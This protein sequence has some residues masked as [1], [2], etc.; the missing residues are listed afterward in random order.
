MEEL[1]EFFRHLH[2]CLESL[3]KDDH[4]IHEIDPIDRFIQTHNLL[5]GKTKKCIEL[6][7]DPTSKT[8]EISDVFMC[9]IPAKEIIKC[10]INAAKKVGWLKIILTD[11]SHLNIGFEGVP[12]IVH[13]DLRKLSLLKYGKTWYSHHFGFERVINSSSFLDEVERIVKTTKL[14]DLI[15]APDLPDGIEFQIV[16]ELIE[17]EVNL[18]NNVLSIS[19]FFQTMFDKIPCKKQSSTWSDYTCV[20]TVKFLSKAESFSKLVD[21]VWDAVSHLAGG[22][23]ILDLPYELNLQKGGRK[24][25]SVKKKLQ[26]QKLKTRRAI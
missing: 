26:K 22:H 2:K 11:A 1:D 20:S 19:E 3:P 18:K 16:D 21:L 14:N 15:L 9:F 6:D 5:T 24:K 13:I 23:S 25:Q 8:I 4:I 7:F 12:D 17:L 10:I